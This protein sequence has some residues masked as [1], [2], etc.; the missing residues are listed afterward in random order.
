MT[1]GE[2]DFTFD[3]PEEAEEGIEEETEEPTEEEEIE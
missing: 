3:I 2:K 1:Y